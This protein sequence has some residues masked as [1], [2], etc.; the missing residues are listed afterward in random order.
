[1]GHVKHRIYLG[2]DCYFEF[3]MTK[4]AAFYFFKI[5]AAMQQWRILWLFWRESILEFFK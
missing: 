2:P 4:A 5:V 3:F 1:M